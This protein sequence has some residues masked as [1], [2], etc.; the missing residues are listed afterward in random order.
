MNLDELYM[1][2]VSTSS[3]RI[4]ERFHTQIQKNDKEEQ[5]FEKL[6]ITIMENKSWREKVLLLVICLFQLS[7]ENIM[8]GSSI[9]ITFLIFYRWLGSIFS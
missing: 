3:H 4:L 5:I 9:L 8:L 1:I 7:L 2:W 6:N